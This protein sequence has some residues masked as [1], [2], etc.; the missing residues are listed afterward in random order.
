MYAAVQAISNGPVS[1]LADHIRIEGLGGDDDLRGGA[2]F[3]SLSGGAGHDTL[4]GG[5]GVDTFRFST[6][7]SVNN[8]DQVVAFDAA[9]DSFEFVHS[10]YN[11]LDIGTLAKSEFK[12]GTGAATT[13]QH[14]IYNAD[15]GDLFYDADGS[16]QGAAV[17]I[18]H[19]DPHLALTFDNFHIV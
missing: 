15:T 9:A 17:E 16:A 2:A 14:I 7:A 18:A 5:G 13:H 3:D 11:A 8:A 1:V 12:I 4:V 6:A 10:A 19:L